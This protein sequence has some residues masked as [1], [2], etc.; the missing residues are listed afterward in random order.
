MRYDLIAGGKAKD[1][2]YQ[3]VKMGRPRRDVEP[4]IHQ[5]KFVLIPGEDDDLIEFF[6][7]L[8]SRGKASAV[9]TA[10][11]NGGVTQALNASA[12]EAAEMLAAL[13]DFLL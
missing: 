9:K 8:P 10:M 12:A 6:A 7:N 11:R 4:V 2:I 13:D 3:G 5:V 1:I